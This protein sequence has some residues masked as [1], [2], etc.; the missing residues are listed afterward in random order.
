ENQIEPSISSSNLF[1]PLFPTSS[2]NLPVLHPSIEM[3][4]KNLWDILESCKKTLP[5]HHLQNKR[6]CIDLSCWMV[7]LENVNK[8]HCALKEKLYLKGLFHRLR[9]LIALN[10]SLILVAD[11][12]IPGIKL[13]TYRRRLNSS[14]EATQDETGPRNEC[15]LPRNA[16]S[17]FS[18]MVK[19]A[20]LLG[21]AL[22][23]P[24][25]DSMEE[26]E[27][28]CAVLNAESQCDGCFSSDSD[29]FLFGART[30]YRDISLSDGGHVVCYEMADIERK[31]GFGRNSLITLALL[32]GSD[33]SN[34]VYGLGPVCNRQ[35]NLVILQ[36]SACQIVKTIGDN[37][38]LQ[39]IASEGLSFVKKK[40]KKKPE[41]PFD[42]NRE[43]QFLQVIDAYLKPKCHPVD[44]ETV[45][46]V[47]GLYQFQQAKLQQICAD[48]FDWP[49]EKTDEYILP[50]VAERDLRRFAN[51]RS[52]SSK[53]GVAPSLE[54]MPVKCPMVE[55]VKPR[56]VQGK[57]CFE[58]SWDGFDGL[59][60][61]IVPAD[62]VQKACPEKIAE[63][64]EK[65]AQAK[66]QKQRKPRAKKS[67]KGYDLAELDSKLQNLMLEIE[68]GTETSSSVSSNERSVEMSKST[69]IDLAGDQHFNKGFERNDTTTEFI[70]LSTP[71]TLLPSRSRTVS[72]CQNEVD[73][74]DIVIPVIDLSDSDIERS[75]EHLRKARDL[76]LFIASIKDDI[77]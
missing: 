43:K 62:L 6:V 45:Y 9:A 40:S 33:Y 14:T 41:I 58:V 39:R 27:A 34:G 12:S 25:L 71:A 31:L 29:I 37:T 57:E 75:P 15:S 46:R 74:R 8:S 36:E 53:L 56:K 10:C 5:L 64:E 73:D 38:V 59:K 7:Q 61:S 4:V 69:I 23:I 26:A 16:G 49:S 28:Q 68:S 32:L 30:V 3:G 42:T 18:R 65:K 24:C 22:G 52:T 72:T 70:D 55:I 13:A 17:E 11:G 20:K 47:L 51:L 2:S 63:F 77:H 1:F 54:M 35:C 21:S 19:E 48:F 50:K 60:T 67:Q 76:R 44:S 66:K